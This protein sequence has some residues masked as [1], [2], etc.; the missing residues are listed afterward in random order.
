LLELL[1]EGYTALVQTREGKQPAAERKQQEHG[2]DG[3]SIGVESRALIA[4][5][6]LFNQS[7]WLCIIRRTEY[8][9]RI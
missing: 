3:A 6:T 1:P 4:L 9:V 8:P 7:G 2:S 5:V